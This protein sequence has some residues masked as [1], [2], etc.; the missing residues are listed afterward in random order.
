MGGAVFPPIWL[1]GL[2]NPALE[3]SG[4]LVGLMVASGRAH[5][6]STSQ[7][8]CC[9]CLCPL[10]EPQLPPT[11]AG[12][13]PILAGRSGTAFSPLDPDVCRTLCVPFK[14]GVSV[15]PS[16]V[17]VLQSNPSGLQSQIIWV[18]LLLLQDPEAGKPDLGLKTFTL[19]GDLLWYNCFPVCGSPTWCVWD[20]LLS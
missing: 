6:V 20:L 14:S 17:E 18:P 4:C 11:S 2:S 19:V 8:W 12:D 7:K 1:L 16:P 5:T 9:Q 3:P 10:S 15:S 13:L